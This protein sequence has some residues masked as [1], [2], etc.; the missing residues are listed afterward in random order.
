MGA[1]TIQVNY[2]SDNLTPYA[3]VDQ[4]KYSDAIL[5]DQNYGSLGSNLNYATGKVQFNWYRNN[6]YGYAPDATAGKLTLAYVYFT[7]TDSTVTYTSDDFTISVITLASTT[8]TDQK[9]YTCTSYF[10]FDVTGDLGG[11]KVVALYAST[12]GG[13]NKQQLECYTTTDYDSTTM[14]YADATTT[15]LVA[16]ENTKSTTAA[17]DIT[18]YGQLEDGTYVSLGDY[19]QSNFLVQTFA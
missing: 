19:T 18:I 7:P 14:E 16:V 1:Y 5:G 6:S 15:F 13:E 2:D 10:T 17:V 11:N 8:G 4:L 9:D 3:V 12:D